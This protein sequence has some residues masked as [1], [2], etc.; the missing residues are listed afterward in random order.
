MRSGS[1]DQVSAQRQ[2]RTSNICSPGVRDT[3]SEQPFVEDNGGRLMGK[4]ENEWLSTATRREAVVAGDRLY[5][6]VCVVAR[7]AGS[8]PGSHPH[9]GH[10]GTGERVRF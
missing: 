3:I 4:L 7:P 9:S 5:R 1:R 2:S 10:E 8:L 6:R